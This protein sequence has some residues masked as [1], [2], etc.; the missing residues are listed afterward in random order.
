M[1]ETPS[2]RPEPFVD[3]IL[4]S[5]TFLVLSFLCSTSEMPPTPFVFVCK[6]TAPLTY[7]RVNSLDN[8]TEMRSLNYKW[9]VTLLCLLLVLLLLRMWFW[10][11]KE[12]EP[13][14]V[15]GLLGILGISTWSGQR[16]C[17]G[18]KLDVSPPDHLVPSCLGYKRRQGYSL[19]LCS[20]KIRP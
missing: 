9:E 6:R 17:L 5:L 4:E 20:F 19:S 3:N 12:K 8:Q 2:E 16:G 1:A 18:R 7:M 14:H 15:K 10:G 13:M 11:K